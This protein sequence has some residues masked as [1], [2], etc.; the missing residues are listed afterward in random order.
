[1]TLSRIG[2]YVIERELGSGGMGTV[3]L[4][5]HVDGGTR[6][7]V[8]ILPAALSREPGFVARFSREI[9]ALHAVKSPQIVE[10]LESGQDGETYYYAMEYV[11]GETLTELLMRERRLP[12]RDVVAMV[13]Q[14]C[15]ALKAAHDAGI[16]HRDLKPSNLLVSADR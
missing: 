6:A 13:L 3:Y 5:Q 7:A 11:E 8:K 12:W 10:L 15:A 2:P 16:I 9:D 1:M 14:M 4:A